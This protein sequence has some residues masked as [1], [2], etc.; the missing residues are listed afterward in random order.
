MIADAERAARSGATEEA[1]RLYVAA[2]DRAVAIGSWTPAAR[3]YRH[4]VELD[5]FD[6]V[7]VQRLAT[8]GARLPA[9]AEWGAYAA[10]L[11]TGTMPPF[12]YTSIQ[13]VVSNDG[14]EVVAQPVG[15]VL[16][17][18]LTGDDLVEA[19]PAPQFDAMP[20]AMA[21]LVIRRAL[22]PVPR[23]RPVAPMSVWVAYRGR[24]PVKLD[25]L[26]DWEVPS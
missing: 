17:V 16:D 10:A 8:Y 7:A 24:Q 11:R 3:C 21:L 2:G 4:A 13:L 5:L 22:W 1:R 12:Q 23:L 26:G 18:L 9:R 19:H 6:G 25:E 14:A 15:S 20:L